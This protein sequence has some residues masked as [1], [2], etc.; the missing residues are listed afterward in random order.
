MIRHTLYFTLFI[1]GAISF[2]ACSTPVRVMV[3][4]YEDSNLNNRGDNVPVTLLIYQ[5]K[6][7]KRFEYASPQDLLS[8]ESVVLGRDKIDSIR[9]QIPPNEKNMIAAEINKKEGKYI[10]I[11]ALFANSQNKTQKF[12]KKLNR[13]CRNI[14]RLDITQNGITKASKKNYKQTQH[15]EVENNGQ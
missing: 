6:D 15:T 11:L 2:V 5:L 8:R 4:N 3:S 9:V 13:V 10:G 7:G 14:I 1:V 12:H